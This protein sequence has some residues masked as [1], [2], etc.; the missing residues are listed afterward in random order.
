MRLCGLFL[1]IGASCT[2][3]AQTTWQGLQFGTDRQQVR[4]EL[5]KSNF[6][7]QQGADA[8]IVI[9]TPDFELRTSSSTLSEALKPEIASASVFFTPVLGF[10]AKDKLSIVRLSLDQSKTFQST[11]ALNSNLPNLTFLA[12]TSSYEQL[13]SKY[14]PPAAT[15]GPCG[16]I[17]I[18]E[19]VGFVTECSARWNG[20]GQTIELFWNYNWTLSSLTFT[21]TYSELSDALGALSLRQHGGER[22]GGTP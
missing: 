1:C 5:A 21:I 19:L 11:P 16:S 8:R 3:V 12:G 15:R 10:G 6:S 18:A 20:A 14:G 2:C 22:K 9:V 7:V 13:I 17:P 4:D